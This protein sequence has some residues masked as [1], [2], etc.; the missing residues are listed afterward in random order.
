[1]VAL[2]IVERLSFD[3]TRCEIQF[4][5]GVATNIEAGIAEIERLR[6]RV[7]VLEMVIRQDLEPDDC[8]DDANRMIVEG[9]RETYSVKLGH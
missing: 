7:T 2:D 5:K 1:M 3:A 6:R 8:S 9:I 4:S